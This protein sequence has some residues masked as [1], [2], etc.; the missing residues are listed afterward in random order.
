MQWIIA[1]HNG[2]ADAAGLELVRNDDEALTAGR[3][4]RTDFIIEIKETA[5]WAAR[6]SAHP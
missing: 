1:A 5:E 4:P 3:N 2:T 6:Y